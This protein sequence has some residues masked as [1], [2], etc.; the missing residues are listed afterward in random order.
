MSV[1]QHNPPSAKR[2][3]F[4]DRT[5]RAVLRMRDADHRTLREAIILL[6]DLAARSLVYKPE[7]RPFDTDD[8]EEVSQ[9]VEDVWS[10]RIVVE[11]TTA[12]Q[13]P[14]PT[15]TAPSAYHQL[16]R[17]RAHATFMGRRCAVH[18]PKLSADGLCHKHVAR[19]AEPVYL[20]D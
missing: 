18:S 14:R 4:N 2:W 11:A 12:E 5:V 19:G 6:V 7:P 13:A 15:V 8:F 9:F 20:A 16:P 1:Q 3:R 10:G 17:C